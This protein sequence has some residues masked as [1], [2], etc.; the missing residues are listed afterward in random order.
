MPV[1]EIDRP[2]PRT[3][4]A[5]QRVLQHRS[6]VTGECHGEPVSVPEHPLDHRSPHWQ[7]LAGDQL[8]DRLRFTGRPR[9]VADPERVARLASVL[10]DGLRID[11]D[12]G[13]G[14]P[15]AVTK[16]RLTEVL[17][18]DLHRPHRDGALAL[19]SEALACGSLIDALFRQLVTIGEIVDPMGDAMAALAVDDRHRELLAWIERL[20]KSDRDA[21]RSEVERQ[22]RGLRLRW[23]TL[24]PAWL[25]RTQETMRA[26][27]SKGAVVLS[28]RVDLA[29]GR[30]ATT[31]A[32]IALVEVKAG[33]RRP[34]HRADLH[35]YALIEALRHPAPPFVVATYYTRTGEL[36]V[37]PV[38]DDLL[39]GAAR[40]TLAGTRSLWN[41]AHG[42]EPLPAPADL[43]AR[44]S[45]VSVGERGRAVDGHT[46]SATGHLLAA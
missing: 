18:C 26:P 23:P 1:M 42:S 20:A 32:S 44:C 43:C 9:P 38:T 28:G 4:V 17:C 33:A 8:L 6:T 3:T 5:R 16:D 12:D 35:Y 37:E 10:E 19:P 14:L 40:R 7:P 21:L 27:L 22:A 24:N 13:R 36:D 45:S 46:G 41:L 31:E 2:A 29:I 25:P 30:P 15:L 34:E 39:L 11:G